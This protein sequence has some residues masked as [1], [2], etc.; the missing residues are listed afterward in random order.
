MAER[1]AAE[2]KSPVAVVEGTAEAMP[3][4]NASF[5]TVLTTWSLCS[6]SDVRAALRE[7]R[8]VL[9]PAGA[10]IFIEHGRAPDKSIARW[11]DRLT[12]FWSPIS[13]GCHLNRSIDLLIQEAGFTVCELRR[14]YIPGPKPFTFVYDGRATP[15]EASRATHR[16]LGYSKYPDTSRTR[17]QSAA[18]FDPCLECTPRVDRV[19]P[20]PLPSLV[21]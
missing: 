8:R 4:E 2:V 19:P 16:S 13:G 11:Q 7:V 12:P 10:L 20:C 3:F 21:H 18:N 17:C 15:A 5:D 9:K 14:G 1:R 6:I